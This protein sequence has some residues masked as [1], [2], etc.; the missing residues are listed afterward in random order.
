MDTIAG[1]PELRAR[2]YRMKAATTNMQPALLR[3][4]LAVLVAAKR[5]IQDGG[6]SL[7]AWSP[8]KVQGNGHALLHDTGRLINSLTVGAQGNIDNVTATQIVVGTNVNYAAALQ[9]GVVMRSRGTPL[10]NRNGPRARG[11]G[12]I[13]PRPFLFIDVGL[14]TTI[15]KIFVASLA[16]DEPGASA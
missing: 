5:N 8:R 10:V 15:R 3:S 7:G 11:G 16:G 2:L 12:G 1:L 14:T 6:S 13:P 9:N 4:G